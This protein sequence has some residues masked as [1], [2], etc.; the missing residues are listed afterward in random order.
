MKRIFASSVFICFIAMLLNCSISGDLAG[1][2]G[3]GNP[4]GQIVVAMIID[5]IVFD[6]LPIDTENIPVT[7]NGYHM[8]WGSMQSAYDSLSVYDAGEMIFSI[9]STTLQVQR[10]H[11]IIQQDGDSLLQSFQ[12]NTLTCDSNSIILEGPF[13]FNAMNGICTPALDSVRLPEA[14][15]Y[16]IQFELANTRSC[17]CSVYCPIF[18]GGTFTYNQSDRRFSMFLSGNSHLSVQAFIPV[19]VSYD[20]ITRFGVNL[21]ASQWLQTVDIKKG[22]DS[23]YIKFNNM[24]NIEINPNSSTGSYSNV[25]NEISNQ[26][27]HN[28]TLRLF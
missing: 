15:Y 12:G 14:V 28:A 4:G 9:D 21:D 24:N 1:S 8:N 18:V 20:K 2:S 7:D 27:L 25:G 17:S 13:T 11:F 3:S 6:S 19:Q 22:I 10:I 5:T 26:I 23:S 16:G